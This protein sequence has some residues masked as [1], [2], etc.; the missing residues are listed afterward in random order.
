MKVVIKEF[1]EQEKELDLEYP[2][3][4][5]FQD[6]YALYDTVVKVYPKYKIE[7]KYDFSGV[8]IE[9]SGYPNYQECQI[10]NNLTTEEHF[11]DAFEEA[12]Q[13]LVKD[14]AGL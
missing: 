4:L 1:L 14:K 10:L 3:Y 5:Y 8:I 7:V 6:E 9:R 2:Y 13:Q 12:L 11:D